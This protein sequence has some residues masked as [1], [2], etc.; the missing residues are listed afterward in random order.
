MATE[1]DAYGWERC[2]IGPRPFYEA[3]GLIK[4]VTG[5]RR[6]CKSC[7][8]RSAMD[9]LHSRGVSESNIAYPNLMEFLAA[10]G[11]LEP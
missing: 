6:C 10:D 2:L 5:I 9:G 11:E 1:S 4:V 7:L 3:D 8:L